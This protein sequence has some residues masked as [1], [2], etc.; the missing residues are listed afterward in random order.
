LNRRDAAVMNATTLARKIAA[1]L[2]QVQ[3]I[4]ILNL[5]L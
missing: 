3:Q 4:E 5:R 1:E 2:L